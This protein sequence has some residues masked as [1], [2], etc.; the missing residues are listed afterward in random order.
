[1]GVVAEQTLVRRAVWV[2]ATYRAHCGI[3]HG[4]ALG[5]AQNQELLKQYAREA[6]QGHRQSAA[7]VDG[8]FCGHGCVQ[9][10]PGFY[11]MLNAWEE[12]I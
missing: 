9:E 4:G 3:S 2:Y 6:V 10:D 12:D 7:V 11:G 5:T 8:S 1:M